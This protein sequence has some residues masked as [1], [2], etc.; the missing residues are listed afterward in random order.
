MGE[1][2]FSVFRGSYGKESACNAGD[3]GSI[4]GLKNPPEKGMATH[5]RILAWRIPWTEELGRLQ[6]MG[7][8]RVGHGWETNT[9]FLLL[10]CGEFFNKKYVI[11]DRH[12]FIEYILISLKQACFGIYSGICIFSTQS[13]TQLIWWSVIQ[14]MDPD[15]FHFLLVYTLRNRLE[16]GCLRFSPG[17]LKLQE[18]PI[19]T[20]DF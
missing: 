15:C 6:S 14:L 17:C 20:N 9:F 8:Q 7:S 13:Q 3:W 1:E 18:T 16:R 19:F 10:K 2:V 5:S 11:I 4:P 12:Q